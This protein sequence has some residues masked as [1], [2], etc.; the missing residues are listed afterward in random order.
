MSERDQVDVYGGFDTH[1]ETHAGAVVDD[2]GRILGVGV[3][4]TGFAGECF[5]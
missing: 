5:G 2:G 4:R 1:R 3:N